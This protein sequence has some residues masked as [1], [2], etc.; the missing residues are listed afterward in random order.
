MDAGYISCKDPLLRSGIRGIRSTIYGPCD[1]IFLK[2]L[3]EDD[4]YARI[5]VNGDD[6]LNNVPPL[7]SWNSTVFEN[8]LKDMAVYTF[9]NSIG[10]VST[11]VA[12]VY[13]YRLSD[14]LIQYDSKKSPCFRSLVLTEHAGT[15]PRGWLQCPTAE[16]RKGGYR[17]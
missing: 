15:L 11:D 4:Q 6:L 2:R 1:G 13:D 8:I 7:L 3:D 17:P 10:Q 5:K 12:G 14:G 16:A 9:Q